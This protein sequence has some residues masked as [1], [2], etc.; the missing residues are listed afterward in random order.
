MET[1][2]LFM[3]G[4]QHYFQSSAQREAKNIFSQLASNLEPHVFLVGVL[5][6][7]RDDCH[8][9]C[10]EPEDCGYTPKQF[11]D[12]K[13]LAQHFEAIDPE[14]DVLHGDPNL[15]K[16]YEQN[17][18]LNALKTA[19]HQIV[20]GRS[21][22]RN[23][24]SF[25]S[26]PVFVKQY[27]VIVVLQFNRKTYLAQYA[28][29]KNKF[30]IFTLNTSL[31][32]ATV[33]VCL[34]HCAKALRKPDPGF[35]WMGIFERDPD[36]IIFAAGKN[37]MYTP[38]AACDKFGNWYGLFE[39][40]NTISSL[41]H[42][43]AEGI[44]RILLSKRRH[45]NIETTLAFSTPVK[46]QNYGAVRKLLEMSSGETCLLSDS[47]YIYGLGKI[48]GLYEQRAEDLFSINFTKYYTWELLHANH[49]M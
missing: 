10:L 42:E 12:V 28:L 26:Y 38:L 33:D 35:D 21:E 37:L 41:K 27:W 29:T 46:M 9:I 6:E 15:Q 18:K 5:S 3:W 20:S 44:G 2:E 39:A 30:N 16:D 48:K 14:R 1:I 4:Y 17:L 23:I 13:K 49:V 25:C 40:C 7:K 19:V 47:E 31:L 34:Q 11:A 32:D 24:I 45:P 43:G 22:Y 8:P 36:E